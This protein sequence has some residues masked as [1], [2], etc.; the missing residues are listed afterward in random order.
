MLKPELK[1]ALDEGVVIPAHPLALTEDR[2]LDEERQRVLTKYYIASGAGGVAVGVH[3]TQ[4]EIRDN[5]V[6]LYE[7][8]LKLAAEEIDNARLDRPFLK[9]AGICGQTDQALEE[10]KLA[11]S[12]GYDL[13]L[14]SNGGLGDW[15]EEALL[16]RTRKVSEVIPVFGFYLQPSVGGRV[17]SY[18][19]WQQYAEIPG[20]LAI[21]I[22]PFNRYQTLDVV[23]AVCHSSR[24]DEIALY[25][26]NDDNIV[27][28]LL[29]SFRFNIGGEII[30]KDIV[31]GLLGHWAV[32]T[33]TA[34]ELLEM[35]QEG[36]KQK[37]LTGDL[38]ELGSE[39]T[40]ANS[41]FFDSAHHFKGCIA[42][43]NEVLRR[44]GLL[45]GRWCLDP[46]EDLSHG[47][48]EEISRIYKDYPH[49]NDDLFI[50]ENL[51][52]WITKSKQVTS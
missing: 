51:N 47:Q 26:G 28:D 2:Q 19:F 24:R 8:V 46:K 1:K 45:R 39:I 52:N 42:G 27:A 32:W 23:R 40:D 37:H 38:L 48:S 9:I 11:K 43:I 33:K 16:E 15:S 18:E 25:T 4:F 14:V 31:G 22:A 44:Q 34:V 49:L 30:K 10:A 21:K 12:L 17:F 3:T 41:A 5:E 29:T 36:K 13:G 20:V 35:V 7:P 6:G 50:K